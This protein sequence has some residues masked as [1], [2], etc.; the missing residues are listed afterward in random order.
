LTTSRRPTTCCTEWCEFAQFRCGFT[1]FWVLIEIAVQLVG[2]LLYI[3]S[4]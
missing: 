3:K 4:K 2:D 1:E